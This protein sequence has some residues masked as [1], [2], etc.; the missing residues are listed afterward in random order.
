MCG[1]SGVN[2]AK[3]MTSEERTRLEL[4]GFIE[5]SLSEEDRVKVR[6]CADELRQLLIESPL[7]WGISM[8]LVGAEVLAE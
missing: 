2:M 8:A 4:I 6:Q 7:H 5:E 1:H 3:E